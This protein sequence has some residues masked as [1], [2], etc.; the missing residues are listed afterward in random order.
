MAIY[1][2]LIPSNCC[3]NSSNSLFQFFNNNIQPFYF[4]PVISSSSSRQQVVGSRQQQFLQSPILQ[5]DALRLCFIGSVPCCSLSCPAATNQLFSCS[6]G[7][8]FWQRRGINKILM[9][10]SQNLQ[11]GR[12]KSRKVVRRRLH[13]LASKL[14]SQVH[15]ANLNY[16]V[17]PYL[18]SWERKP[19][20]YEKMNQQINMSNENQAK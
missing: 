8:F 4:N 5:I 7:A 12:G 19:N 6:V 15:L 3:C 16:V 20:L 2:F 18:Y 11:D 9:A 1:P 13:D 10:N 17:S 14:P